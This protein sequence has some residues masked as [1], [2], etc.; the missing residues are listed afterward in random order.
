MGEQLN[1]DR[2]P[3]PVLTGAVAA[4]YLATLMR[5]QETGAAASRLAA[6]ATAAQ[7]GNEAAR[8]RLLRALGPSPRPRAVAY[9]S[10]RTRPVRLVTARR[11]RTIRCHTG[12]SPNRQPAADRDHPNDPPLRA[13]ARWRVHA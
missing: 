10:R 8:W 13:A 9:C 12:R 4:G 7:H 5:T 6:D 2:D 11:R 3:R 1:S